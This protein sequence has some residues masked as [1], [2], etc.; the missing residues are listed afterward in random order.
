MNRGRNTHCTGTIISLRMMANRG[1]LPLNSM[2]AKAKAQGTEHTRQVTTTAAARMMEFRPYLVKWAS[3]Q[4]S[5]KLVQMNLLGHH[6]GGLLMAS[7]VDLN[8][9][10]IM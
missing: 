5:A 1:F 2:R 8:E 10:M 9:E 3:F 7:M 6:T 4:A